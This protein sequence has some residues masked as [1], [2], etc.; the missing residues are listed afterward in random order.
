MDSVR[1]ESWEEGLGS[2]QI[3]LSTLWVG[4]LKSKKLSQI[5]C[6]LIGK[7]KPRWRKYLNLSKAWLLYTR[8]FPG[9]RKGMVESVLRVSCL[10]LHVHASVPSLFPLKWKLSKYQK[11]VESH[12]VPLCPGPG[13]R[14]NQH[15]FWKICRTKK[16][17]K[18]QK[19]SD[20]FQ[21]SRQAL[22]L[23]NLN[24]LTWCLP[25]TN[26]HVITLG[27]EHLPSANDAG[28]RKVKYFSCSRSVVHWDLN[29]FL[30]NCWSNRGQRTVLTK[31]W[32]PKRERIR[33]WKAREPS[34]L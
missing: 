9:W 21:L 8:A 30:E 22:Y 10:V 33:I 14:K 20:K 26:S 25:I 13:N 2:R 31:T 11:N 34:V 29:W 1:P 12:K 4:G 24:L 15:L 23:S 18:K 3:R 6:Y 19:R 32:G 28:F 5:H 17:K 7:S 16:R 27:E